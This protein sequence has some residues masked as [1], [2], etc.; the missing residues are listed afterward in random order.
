[1][2]VTRHVVTSADV[3]LYAETRGNPDHPAI[4]LVHGYPDNHIVW[5]PLAE[6]LAD[7]FFVIV[8][9]VRGAGQSDKPRRLAD[10]RLPLLAQDLKAVADQLLPGRKFHLAA[11]DWGSIQ[12]WESVTSGLLQ[13]RILSFSSISGP[14]LDHMGF[15]MRSHLL[16][17]APRRLFA[18]IRQLFASWYIAFFQVP[19]LPP[20]L[21]RL[22]VARHWGRYLQWREGVCE[23]QVNPTQ[24]DDGVF[25]VRL[26]RAN[27]IPRLL[28]PEQRYAHCPVQ[29]IVPTRDNYV[30]TQLFDELGDWVTQLYRRD[31]DASHWAPLTH[32]P[33]LAQWLAEFAHAMA[34]GEDTQSLRQARIPG[35]AAG[36]R[37]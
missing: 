13:G 10:Y 28:R 4:I 36:F 29:L 9:D 11:H 5:Q 15:W 17:L 8:Y 18:G 33:Q 37:N 22:L 6:Q 27:F 19:L 25:G 30:G 2:S 35:N 31:L 26:Y 20:L 16:S 12:S 24:A 23:P 14:S 32:A 21:W 1:M 3:R 7:E 34:S